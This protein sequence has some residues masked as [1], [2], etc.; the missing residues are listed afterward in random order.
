MIAIEAYIPPL[1]NKLK[2]M[3]IRDFK[4]LYHFRVQV[5]VDLNESIQKWSLL[6]VSV[7]ILDNTLLQQLFFGLMNTWLFNLHDYK[8]VM[9]VHATLCLNEREIQ[10]KEKKPRQED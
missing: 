3:G 1:A 10:K 8:L 7:I 4:E 2:N 9:I 5:E 6:V